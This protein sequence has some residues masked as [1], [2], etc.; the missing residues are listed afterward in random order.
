VREG[1]VNTGTREVLDALADC[2]PEDAVRVET[3]GK[4]DRL[5]LPKPP[6]ADYGLYIDTH[7]GGGGMLIGAVPTGAA[8][9]VFF[10]HLPLEY[11]PEDE[12]EAL[13]V[14]VGV[15]GRLILN[16]SRILQSLGFLLSRLRC[17][18]EEG[19]EWKRVGGT[20]ASPRLFFMPPLAFRLK[21]W[22]YHSASLQSGTERGRPT[23]R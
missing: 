5:W 21:T 14:L 8:A 11:P 15:A 4:R 20:I 19:G 10:W 12:Q 18:V 9:E 6:A 16:R 13:R 7:R 17:E 22:E 2:L 23:T 1:C 3:T